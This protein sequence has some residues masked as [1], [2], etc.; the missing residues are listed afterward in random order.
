MPFS[1][2]EMR[3]K[4]PSIPSILDKIDEWR[5]KPPSTPLSQNRQY[6]STRGFNPIYNVKYPWMIQ[7]KEEDK[8]VGLLCSVCRDHYGSDE[9][10]LQMR[11][12]GGKWVKVPFVKFGDL[13]EEARKHEFG[14]IPKLHKGTPPGVLREKLLRGTISFEH[15]TTHMRFQ[16]Q[17]E[18]L[19]QAR[20]TGKT[21]D[22][23]IKRIGMN[24]AQR[25]AI[26]LQQLCALVHRA[27]KKRQSPFTT[28]KDAAIFSLKVLKVDS[29]KP[30]FRNQEDSGISA[31]RIN[32]IVD[33]LYDL[34]LLGICFE[35][36]EGRDET[37]PIVFGG[38]IDCGSKCRKTK[39]Y[40]G[41]GIKYLILNEEAPTLMTRTIAFKRTVYKD[42]KALCDVM[43]SSMKEVNNRMENLRIKLQHLFPLKFIP[44][45]RLEN[46]ESL[47]VDGACISKHLM[48][49]RRVL[50]YNQ[51]CITNWCGSHKS[52]LVSNDVLNS[53]S[54]HEEAHN[55]REKLFDLVNA[56]PKFEDLFKECQRHTFESK[57]FK[58][59]EP[60]VMSN[61]PMHRWE[62]TL[63]FDLNLEKLLLST[64]NFLSEVHERRWA[65]NANQT[66]I[67]PANYLMKKF[68]KDEFLVTM[69][70]ETDVLEVL[71]HFVKNTEFADQDLSLFMDQVEDVNLE[72][73]ALE[74]A[75]GI[76]TRNII[77]RLMTGDLKNW[78]DE[79]IDEETMKD[80]HT[81]SIGLFRK[82]WDERFGDCGVLEMFKFFS[83]SLFQKSVSSI[84]EAH[85]FGMKFEEQLADYYCEEASFLANYPEDKG[86]L[87]TSPGIGS[88]EHFSRDCRYYKRYVWRNFMDKN[89]KTGKPWRTDE[90]LLKI[91]SSTDEDV[92]LWLGPQLRYIMSCC[93]VQVM[94]SA[95]VERVMSTFDLYDDKLNQAA[96][97]PTVEK[98]VL[99]MKESPSWK[100]FDGKSA[101]LLWRLQKTVRKLSFPPVDIL[102]LKPD[103]GKSWVKPIHEI[104]SGADTRKQR[105]LRRLRLVKDLEQDYSEGESGNESD[106]EEDDKV[107]ESS[108]EE[109]AMEIVQLKQGEHDAIESREEGN[110]REE[111][112]EE[113]RLEE[114]DEVEAPSTS[115]CDKSNTETHDTDME[116]DETD[117]TLSNNK[118]KKDM[119]VKNS[120][121]K[122]E[123]L[124]RKESS[125]RKQ[126]VK[127]IRKDF[128]TAIA[129]KKKKLITKK[130]ELTTS[131][132]QN[133]K[134]QE[135]VNE[136]LNLVSSDDDQAEQN[137]KTRPGKK[138]KKVPNREAWKLL[139]VKQS[140]KDDEDIS[141]MSDIEIPLPSGR[142]QSTKRIFESSDDEEGKE[143]GEKPMDI[144]PQDGEKMV[145][146]SG[147]DRGVP[148]EVNNVNIHL[149]VETKEGK[150][151]QHTQIKSIKDVQKEMWLLVLY[152]SKVYVG[153]VISVHPNSPEVGDAARIKCLEK[154]YGDMDPTHPQD[155]ESIIN[156]VLHPLKNL[157]VCPVR[158]R[159]VCRNRKYLWMYQMDC[160]PS[161]SAPKD[162]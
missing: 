138:R 121:S 47:G 144:V 13:A 119:E 147:E 52:A 60:V 120:N 23:T 18:T 57:V 63:K 32:E 4:P 82:C 93:L 113:M 6:A 87:F 156:W 136:S 91:L 62:S 1:L 65:T 101:E 153:Q 19:Q 160:S 55:I 161:P 105:L 46:M 12:S 127:T 135:D 110:E 8:V 40:A 150:L 67:Y 34:C 114:S 131:E 142:K 75:P 53:N 42:G 51:R 122:N 69:A 94:S 49:N 41:V 116:E 2:G 95:D 146:E 33:A 11:K 106:E 68:P 7:V 108:G 128:F 74:A 31:R 71:I 24:Q 99:L 36:S 3:N 29:L 145:T 100:V 9:S 133:N 137:P 21:I 73:R 152:E 140:N 98:M 104:K 97:A 56:S 111:E 130:K 134:E 27:I 78:H 72:L 96:K 88:R 37:D 39:E 126:I 10:D 85:D 157:Y 80:W 45:L 90:A 117:K 159:K 89:P 109:D 35:L 139:V 149:N 143:N 17:S 162:C 76:H 86:M 124:R 22:N 14:S 129:A 154:E 125:S 30:L 15:N 48:V 44:Q 50:K 54:R 38:I 84:E 66:K 81:E 59:E 112:E 148:E 118:L 61:R 25:N 107:G 92:K 64:E 20:S 83:I 5:R 155:F 28:V 102:K 26:A 103:E 79:E 141:D 77:T 58:D 70:I 151:L 132:E 158:V 123:S 115:Y 16:M 43:I